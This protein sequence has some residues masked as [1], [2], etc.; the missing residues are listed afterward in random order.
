MSRK[1]RPIHKGREVSVKIAP[2]FANS[3]SPA[4]HRDRPQRAQPFI[5]AVVGEQKFPAPDCSVVAKTQTIQDDAQHRRRVE[6][7]SIFRQARRD[8]SV[9]VL[10]LHHR[11]RRREPLLSRE[12]RGDIVRMAVN[13][14]SRRAMV[15]KPRVKR[16]VF[17]VVVEGSFVFKIALML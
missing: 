1:L 8:V 9:V 14:E 2:R 7:A 17:A 15:E 16:Q 6:R 10:G 5:A 4:W 3:P 11:R 12:L 13:D